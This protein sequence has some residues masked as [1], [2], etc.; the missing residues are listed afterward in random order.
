M[1]RW[2]N[3]RAAIGSIADMVARKPAPAP[4]VALYLAI[5]W[6]SMVSWKIDAH[7]PFNIRLGRGTIIPGRCT[8]IAS[9]GG[10]TVGRRVE[11]HEGSY[12]HCQ[13]GAIRIGEDTAIGPYVVVYGGGGVMIGSSCGIASHATIVSTTHVADR[14]DEPIR[15]QGDRR[16]PVTISDDVWIGTHCSI[17]M[18]VSIGEG[19]ILGAGTVLLE[20]VGSRSIVVGV[21]GRVARTR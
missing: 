21:P 14:S 11:L 18:G 6:R 7:Y 10:I 8:L 19:T 9:G 5:R 20:S 4:L 3:L 17:L 1:G 13:G 12:L 15:N 2:P 16:M